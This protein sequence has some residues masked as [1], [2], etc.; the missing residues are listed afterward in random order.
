MF[1]VVLLSS[2]FNLNKKACGCAAFSRE[3]RCSHTELSFGR[4]G[5]TAYTMRHQ[6]GMT[7]LGDA[8]RTPLLP[9]IS[10]GADSELIINIGVYVQYY[11]FSFRAYIYVLKM[12]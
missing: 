7:H 1:H 8:P 12:I 2:G 11:E 10:S 3:H 4:E 5:A 6:C 9:A